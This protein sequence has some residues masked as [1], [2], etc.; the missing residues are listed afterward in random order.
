MK[1]IL[2]VIAFMAALIVPALPQIITTTGPRELDT[3]PPPPVPLTTGP[4]ELDTPPPRVPY[5]APT[6]RDWTNMTPD[7]RLYRWLSHRE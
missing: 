7:L 4:R 2:L 6:G 5:S 1:T 3:N